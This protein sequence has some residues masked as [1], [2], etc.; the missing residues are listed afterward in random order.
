MTANTETSVYNCRTAV[1]CRRNY[2]APA[3]LK[4]A[5]TWQYLAK[6]ECTRYCKDL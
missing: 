2:Y 4:S 1:N 3:C 5:A 6:F